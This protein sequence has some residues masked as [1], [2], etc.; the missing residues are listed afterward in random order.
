MVKKL[1]N[2]CVAVVNGMLKKKT[3]GESFTGEI[4]KTHFHCQKYNHRRVL[5]S[6][7]I[8]LVGGIVPKTKEM[9]TTIVSNRKQKT[10]LN[11]INSMFKVI[12]LF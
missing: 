8:W 6:E 5:R 2:V 9:F 3:G 11:A 12:H 4:I 1:L 7:G 10:L